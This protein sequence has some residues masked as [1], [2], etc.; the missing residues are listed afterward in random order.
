MVLFTATSD[1]SEKKRRGKTA[2]TH[3]L[4]GTS[5]TDVEIE[6]DILYA[7]LT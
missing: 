5:D 1:N 2:Y 4:S 3:P 7:L 6:E